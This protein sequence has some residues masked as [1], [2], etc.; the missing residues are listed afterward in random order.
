MSCRWQ[1][2]IGFLVYVIVV[3]DYGFITQSL[4]CPFFVRFRSSFIGSFF[5]A[6]SISVLRFL[7]M[8]S[9]SH[10]KQDLDEAYAHLSILDVEEGRLVVD[11]D[12]VVQL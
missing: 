9:S 4:S 7:I 12:A 5:L 8:A 10:D 2:L 11:E 6:L 3:S 1:C